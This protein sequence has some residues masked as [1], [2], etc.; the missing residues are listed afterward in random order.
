MLILLCI[1]EHPDSPL[2]EIARRLG[3]SASSVTRG[4][5]TL[6]CG[7]TALVEI[8]CQSDD[9]RHRIV[10]LS[11]AGQAVLEDVLDAA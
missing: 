5:Q 6:M 1:A 4:V 7:D 8:S 10:R 2:V 9:A 3:I 11:A